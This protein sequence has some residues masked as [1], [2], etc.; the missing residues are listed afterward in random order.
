M[1]PFAS[2]SGA[3]LSQLAQ[4]QTYS[5]PR[6]LI[7]LLLIP[8]NHDYISNTT[9]MD[10]THYLGLSDQHSP[11]TLLMIHPRSCNCSRA[12][13]P[14]DYDTELGPYPGIC[15]GGCIAMGVFRHLYISQQTDGPCFGVYGS[16]LD[17]WFIV[18][19]RPHQTTGREN[20]GRYQT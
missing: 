15:D 1:A 10:I 14:V 6:N 12:D 4:N 16:A 13:M 9:Q 7:T 17:L 19:G 20:E 11:P 3:S 2:G 18:P 5:T 8:N